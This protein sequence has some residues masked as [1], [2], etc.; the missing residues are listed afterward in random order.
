MDIRNT[1]LNYFQNKDHLILPSSSLIPEDDPSVLL[2]T[3]GMQ[4][5]KPY[6]LGIKKPP[7]KRIA[8]LQ[9]CFRTSDIENIGN[10]DQH[11]TFFEMLGNFAFA[12]YFKKEAIDFAMDFILNILKLDIKKLCVGV[13][14][15]DNDI[16][17][18][19]ESIN[20]W[21]KW[22]VK[23]DKIFEYGKCENFWG[24]AGDTGPC[25]PCTEIYYDFGPEYG[26]ERSDCSPACD[27][28]RFLEIWNLVFTQYN[29]TGKKYEELPNKNIDTGLGL[30]RI[31]AV[32]EK[33]P[34]VFKTGLFKAVVEKIEELS[35][36]KL[37]SHPDK[38][39]NT[40]VNRW[41]KIVA[42]H[43]RAVTFLI[44]DGV[45]PS[46]ESRGYILRRI[47]R[48]AVRFSRLLGIEGNY[49]NQISE[50]VINNY[51]SF[52]PEL[53]D[54]RDTIF[55]IIND[56]EARFSKTLKEGSKLLSQMVKDLKRSGEN[57]LDPES[58]F[59]LYETYGFPVELTIEMLKEDD[60]SLDIDTFRH[61]MKLHS[62][63]SK[64]KTE[65]DK[66]IDA[67]IELYKKISR[68][69]DSEFI[70]HHQ[71]SND[72]KIEYILK[73][74]KDRS[75]TAVSGL[76]KDEEG[77]IV[78]DITPFYAEKGGQIGDR[79]ELKS[80]NNTCFE[81]KDTQVPVEGVIIHKGIVKEGKIRKNDSVR[82][83]VDINFR[84]K[85]SKNHT[86]THILHWALRTVLGKN[87]T[88]SGSLVGEDRFRFDYSH[89]ETTPEEKIVKIE[90]LI[91]EKIQKDDPVRCFETTKEYA[92]EIGAISLF[93][94]KYGK[95]VR[96]VEI[97]DYSRELCGGIHVRR[98]GEIG[99]LKIISDSSI[100]AS[101]RRI[102]AVT[103]L[104]AYDYL[105][106]G[107]KT[108]KKISASLDTDIS[109]VVKR[110]DSLKENSKK[111][112][113]EITNLQIK[114]I[115][116]EILSGQSQEK[117]NKS[118]RIITFNF[119]ESDF[120]IN[121]DA[122]N[123]GLIG[124]EIINELGN[125]NTF[126]IFGNVLKQKPLILLQSTEDL[127]KRKVNCSHMAKD[128]G[129]ILKG[130]GGG[131]PNFAQIGGSD[132]DALNKAIAAAKNIIL[133]K[134]SI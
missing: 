126:I 104:A 19:T 50:I 54:G 8:T 1:F 109:Q 99:L 102:E 127:I 130:G 89:S 66:K 60:L 86:S 79:G 120:N 3:A 133:E 114:A 92:E 59:K 119:I 7:K 105:N 42:D 84:K 38:D 35:G 51:S 71:Y 91:N 116:K 73:K 9:K 95:Y 57:Q 34:S 11:L 78:L 41:I 101:T 111:I 121:I 43:S 55:K 70:G 25:G 103:G 2:T 75:L 15:G 4:Q 14:S 67:N 17:P 108:L 49:L 23:S 74:D 82:A 16:P 45:T 36:E 90:R 76:S 22:G 6:Y 118:V 53:T 48:R 128:I 113:E 10:T 134:L 100:G 56:E 21:K 32:L 87:T 44:A 94:E 81:V 107:F 52:Y 88:Q 20:Y 69:I 68:Q 31:V 13:F 5:F 129:K 83:T 27:C 97:D 72:A 40:E 124:D 122:K 110:I 115:K 132:K 33:N 47:L 123:M 112:Q 131:K 30:E 46:N 64:S 77:E 12:D 37:T 58:S 93:D 98:T 117:D 18:D 80:S 62:E 63:K 65:F 26:C 28:D 24:P 61:Y 96:V 85:I 125:K 29:F 106:N 39:F